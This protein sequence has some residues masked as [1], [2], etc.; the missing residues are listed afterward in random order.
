MQ[1][2]CPFIREL[3]DKSGKQCT[4]ISKNC[5]NL[6]AKALRSMES[7]KDGQTHIEGVTFT[8]P[9]GPV[10]KA[11]KKST[12]CYGESAGLSLRT[13]ALPCRVIMTHQPQLLCLSLSNTTQVGKCDKY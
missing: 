6:Q 4:T 5:T 9:P 8:N 10:G 2:A 11:P 1:S 3:N 12:G 13:N 7:A